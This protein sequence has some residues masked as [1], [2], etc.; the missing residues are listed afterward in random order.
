MAEIGCDGVLVAEKFRAFVAIG[1]AQPGPGQ[2]CALARDK[3]KVAMRYASRQTR[4]LASITTIS[5]TLRAAVEL[6]L[7]SG[8]RRRSRA[9]TRGPSAFA[10]AAIFAR[11][12]S[13]AT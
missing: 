8:D 10:S 7:A 3:S 5:A 11:T 2:V 1:E 9:V 13:R 4:A 12:I 6:R